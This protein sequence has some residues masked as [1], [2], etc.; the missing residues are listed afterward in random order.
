[1]KKINIIKEQCFAFLLILFLFGGITQSYSQIEDTS[2]A[3]RNVTYK[4]RYLESEAYFNSFKENSNIY[5]GEGIAKIENGDIG[6]A[7]NKAKT[8][9]RDNLARN[10]KVKV[11]STVKLIV[12]SKNR[13]SDPMTNEQIDESIDINT[14]TYTD[15]L[16][17]EVK[18]SEYKIDYPMRNHVTIIFYIEKSIYKSIVDKDIEGKKALI[19][20]SIHNGNKKFKAKHYVEAVHD[21]LF[22]NESLQNFFQGLPIQDDIDG[23]GMPKEVNSYINDKIT[24]FFSSVDLKEVS[25]KLFY[26][27]RGQLNESPI[28][29]AEFENDYGDRSAV[30]N[31]PLKIDFI[32]GDGNVRRKIITSPYGQAKLNVKNVDSK[33][34]D[35]IIRITIDKDAFSGIDAFH[36]LTLPYL[37]IY[38]KKMKTVALAVSYD[39][40]GKFSSPDQLKNSIQSEL[41]SRGLQ[42]VPVKIMNKVVSDAD[43]EN[44]KK[45]RAD[46]LLYIYVHSDKGSTVGGYNNMYLSKSSGTLYIYQLPQGNIVASRELNPVKGFGVTAS[47]AGWNGYSKLKNQIFLGIKDMAAELK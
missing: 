33:Y 28:V 6:E 47:G 46:Y 20:N 11:R 29:Y 32:E 31:L 13:A 2:S 9:A 3:Q 42:I 7:I 36:N 34:R 19:R 41:L 12:S 24:F 38:M 16:L 26:D 14:E 17:T 30:E 18:Q 39:N 21:W 10:I 40:N 43:I 25:G 5:F 22:A 44:V 37:D 45:S 27:V 15:Q 4:L 23:T 8:N 35:A 1:M